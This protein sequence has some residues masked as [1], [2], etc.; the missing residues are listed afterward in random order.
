MIISGLWEF[1][2]KFFLVFEY[3]SFHENRAVLKNTQK[4]GRTDLVLFLSTLL[5]HSMAELI[6]KKVS[7]LCSLENV[8]PYL[9]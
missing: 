1:D 3:I 2:K 6:L 8:I 4:C 5:T 9:L 7:Y